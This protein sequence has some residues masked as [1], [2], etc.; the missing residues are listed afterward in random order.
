MPRSRKDYL[1]LGIQ[2]LLFTGYLLPIKISSI[3]SPEWLRY[4]GLII[5]ALGVALGFVALF[6]LNTKL[7]PFPTPVSNGKLITSGA[8]RIARHPI[9][10]AVIFLGLGYAFYSASLFKVLISGLLLTLFYYKSKYEEQLLTQKFSEYP[11]YKKKTRRF[12]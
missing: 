1:Y 8:Y 2:F 9:Y 5:L 6:Q 7:S 10:T 12:I 3:Y 11:A 4:S